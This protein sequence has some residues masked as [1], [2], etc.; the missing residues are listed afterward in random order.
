VLTSVDQRNA[1]RLSAHV[2]ARPILPEGLS[3]AVTCTKE[4]PSFLH[5]VFTAGLF[6]MFFIPWYLLLYVQDAM[7]VVLCLLAP[8]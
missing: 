5:I 3:E 2:Y 6:L 8:R 7:I 1:H 4:S